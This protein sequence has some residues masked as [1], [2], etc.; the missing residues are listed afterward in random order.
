MRTRG[1][2]LGEVLEQRGWVSREQLLRALRNQKV[3]GGRLGTC[4]LEIDAV[5]EDVLLKALAEHQGVPAATPD[6]LRGISQEVIRLV[7][8]KVARR[9]LAV[10]FRASGSSAHIAVFEARDLAALDELAFVSGR[11]VRIC[12]ATEVRLLEALEKYYG[13]EVPPR[14]GKLLDRLNR[15]RFLWAGDGG[16]H[17]ADQ[18]SD[19]LKWDP[20][21]SGREPARAAD[22]QGLAVFGATAGLD[23][24]EI[25]LPEPPVASAETAAA[26]PPAMPPP[27]AATSAEPAPVAPAA[28][29]PGP[30]P[31]AVPAAPFAPAPEPAAV[32]AA[33][34]VAPA[35]PASPAPAS[36]P[37]A[38]TLEEAERRLLSPADRD[39]VARTL[40]EFGA[41]HC[42][43][44]LLFRFQRHE[45]AGWMAAGEALDRPAL[46]AYRGALDRPS[47]F[48]TLHSGAPIA[49]G[50]LPDLP[51]H[52]E[53]RAA[54]GGAPAHDAL[55]LPVTV[56]ERVVAVL[57]CEPRGASFAAGEIA[58]LQRLAAKAAIAFELCIMRAKLRRA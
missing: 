45:V 7:P 54:L 43:R 25:V 29:A 6:D 27:P 58:D 15:A 39:D 40:I 18:A 20:R 34:P 3:V 50:A 9:L 10:P 46:E 2:R 14:I 33:M 26:E 17:P 55:A 51:A 8:A 31:A 57:Y 47:V 36:A 24:P 48:F 5:T 4:L 21:L 28:V 56:R 37:L 11:R 53:I 1:P 30:A 42:R 44:T 16:A 38:T 49:R 32:P 19:L 41:S 52:E 12:V 23:L 22:S 13:E 35:P